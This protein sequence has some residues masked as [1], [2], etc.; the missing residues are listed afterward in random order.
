M[1]IKP[2]KSDDE[3][4]VGEDDEPLREM[5]KAEEAELDAWIERNKDALKT[6]IRKA[7]EEYARGHYYTLEEVMAE[8]RERRNLRG[9]K[10]E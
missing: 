5:T 9:N 1:K 10:D 3:L 4:P 8:I 7:D 6:S 2:A